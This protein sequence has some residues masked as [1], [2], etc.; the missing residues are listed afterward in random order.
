[1]KYQKI[2]RIVKQ[3]STFSERKRTK[4]GGKD[5]KTPNSNGLSSQ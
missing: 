5:F 3:V 1:M 2:K 4:I